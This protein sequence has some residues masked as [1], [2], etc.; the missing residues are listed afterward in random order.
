VEKYDLMAAARL[1]VVPSRFET[2]GIVAIEALAVGTP[3]LGFDIPCLREVIPADCGGV[4]SPF[5]VQA[6]AAEL[7]KLYGKDDYRTNAETAG[8]KFALSYD[9]DK[10][11]YEQEKFY[12]SVANISP[13]GS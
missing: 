8:R 6:Y 10:L 13:S 12:L 7:L 3:V 5:D 2:F 1:V 11:T 9:W 4:V